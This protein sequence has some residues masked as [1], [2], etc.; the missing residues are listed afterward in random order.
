L[1]LFFGILAVLTVYPYAIY[2]LLVGLW[3]RLGARR[4]AQAPGTP[5][6]TLIISAY[7]EEDVIGR[8]VENA[9]ALDYP[10]D[11]LQILV[12]SDGSSDRTAEIVR[13]FPAGRV[14]LLDH[15]TRRGKTACLNDAVP[16]ATG[17]II[18]FTDAN[19]MLPRETMRNI[20]RHFSDPVIGLVTGWTRYTQ[21][22]GDDTGGS[23]GLYARLERATKSSES[24]VSS[25]VGADGAIFGMRR[26]LFQ[27]LRDDDI[28]DFVIPLDVV[29]QGHRVVLD[30]DV[31]CIEEAAE[32]GER[33]FRRQTRI[34]NR[35]LLAI[36]RRSRFLNPLRFGSFA[37]FLMSHKVLRFL[38]PFFFAGSLLAGLQVYTQHGPAAPVA[39]AW[40]I[41][42]VGFLVLGLLGLAWRDLGRLVHVCA[43]LLLTLSAQVVGW[44]RWARGTMDVTWK[45]ER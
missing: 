41:G 20:S 34:T 29:G 38:V 11:R 33:E 14:R 44:S 36:F 12:A 45:P 37:V 26:A 6:A 43:Y 24:A 21:H 32:G 3:S 17:E 28:N 8:K 16:Q 2:P 18:A 9:L 10:A 5:S 1:T 40:V 39:A 25:C 19:A 7:N 30:S 35:T 4:W 13:S 15:G 42:Q 23:P 31:Y 22:H 27:P